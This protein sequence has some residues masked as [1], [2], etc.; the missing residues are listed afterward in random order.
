M[1]HFDEE[2]PRARKVRE[3]GSA[4]LEALLC[5]LAADRDAAGVKYEELRRRLINMFAWEQCEAPDELADEVLN[6]LARKFMDG[7]VIPH[8][9]RF[10]LG[11]ARLVM[12][13]EGRKR[14][15]RE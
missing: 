3:L 7:A 4:E 10:A 13:E 5:A 9:D 14:R 11:I 1:D 6:R 2:T 15:K 12:Q 8:V